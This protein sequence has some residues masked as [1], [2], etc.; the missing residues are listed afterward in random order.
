M[1]V[2]KLLMQGLE[3][4][5][6]GL[7]D[8]AEATYRKVLNA[9]KD[10]LLALKLLVEIYLAQARPDDAIACLKKV[11]AKDR[12]DVEARLAYAPLLIKI[13][14][15]SEAVRVLRDTITIAPASA[16]AHYLLGVALAEEHHYLEAI[17]QCTMALGLDEA[18]TDAHYL[19]GKAQAQLGDHAA[20][21]ADY[22]HT[23]ASGTA[24]AGIYLRRGISLSKLGKIREAASD[25]LESIALNPMSF[26]ANLLL[27]ES[28]VTLKMHQRAEAAFFRAMKIDASRPYVMGLIVSNRHHSCNWNDYALDN[29]YL[30]KMILSGESVESPFYFLN[31]SS[32]ARDQLICNNLRVASHFN[33]QRARPSF[34][35]SPRQKIRIAYVSADYYAHATT[36]LC[37]RLFG[38]HDR[39]DFDIIGISLVSSKN[40]A[41]TEQ[42]KLSFDAYHEVDQL[43][44]DEAAH[45]IRALDI[46]I[47]VDLKGHTKDSRPGIFARHPA[48]VQVNYLGFPG[49]MGGTLMDYIIA[50]IHVIPDAYEAFYSE[51]V[52]RLPGSYQINNNQRPIANDITRREDHGLPATGFVFCCFNNNYKITPDVFSIW[53]R[54]LGKVPGSVLWLLADNQ[55]AMDNLKAEAAQRNVDPARLVF[56]GRMASDVH[57][58]RHRHADLF[59]DTLP[60]N[61]HTTTS[62]ALWA[63]LPVL[64]CTGEAFAARVAASLLHAAGVPELVTHNH[65]DYEALALRL[66]HDADMLSGLKRR[67]EDNRM[68]CDLFNT[69][70]TTRNLEAA[71]KAMHAQRQAGLAAEKITIPDTN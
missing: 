52:A 62:D 14:Q 70:K 25:F 37:M 49:S 10:N 41:T 45:A 31:L 59:L 23:I 48:P 66:A 39:Q 58:A 44:D 56:A 8:S 34:A 64:T 16:Q 15:L 5:K 63:G 2:S 68:R 53:M 13:R 42:L 65:A 43:N 61:A 12:Q 22:D 60:I 35:P 3:Q 32:S 50:D 27:G 4:Y 30:T 11:I 57:L 9:D 54:L 21:I 71:F 1:S 55:E 40:D 46:D 26:E 69:E 38:C 28:L 7:F 6:K 20:A 67:L 29:A 19:R 18:H 47:L 36:A 24:S 17:K 51:K 33:L